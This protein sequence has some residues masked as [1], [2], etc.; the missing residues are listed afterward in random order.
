MTVEPGDFLVDIGPVRKQDQFPKQPALVVVDGY[1]TLPK[2][3]LQR[4]VIVLGDLGCPFD[5]LLNERFDGIHAC[6]QVRLQR[7][8]FDSAHFGE[9]PKGLAQGPL[10]YGPDRV[11]VR[12]LCVE[13]RDVRQGQQLAG[14]EVILQSQAL[15]GRSQ[16]LY[17]LFGPLFIDHQSRGRGCGEMLHVDLAADPAAL[18]L[19]LDHPINLRIKGRQG[20]WR[21]DLDI[22]LAAIDGVDLD[23]DTDAVQRGL[24]T[25]VPCHAAECH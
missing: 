10:Q 2:F 11:P 21:T 23:D 5:D 6:G 3:R 4:L 14:P 15:G 7:R 19:S 25:A 17:V 1:A 9:G 16:G 18:D 13:T 24:S 12:L 8:A 20:A 22:E